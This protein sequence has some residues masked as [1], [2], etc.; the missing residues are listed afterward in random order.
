MGIL[1]DAI[2]EHLEL[3]RRHGAPDD[4]LAKQEAEA[5]GPARRQ[6]AVDPDL[7]AGIDDPGDPLAPPEAGTEASLTGDVP[8]PPPDAAFDPEPDLEPFVP[9]PELDETAVFDQP[10]HAEPTPVDPIAPPPAAVEPEPEPEPEPELEPEPDPEPAPAAYRL[11]PDPE[12][13]LEPEPE[14]LVEDDPFDPPT[15][16]AADDATRVRPTVPIHDDPSLPPEPALPPRREP[17]PAPEPDLEIEP[18]PGE[19]GADDV[20]EETPDF[21]QDTPDHDRLWFEQKPPRDFDFDD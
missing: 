16:I 20:L 9:E 15:Q 14:P 4:E 5:L 10:I 6:P 11:P 1:D 19:A 17:D 2:R 3:K 7:D 12:P 8:P 13:E 18:P 21:L